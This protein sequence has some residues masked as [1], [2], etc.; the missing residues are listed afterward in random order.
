MSRVASLQCYSGVSGDMLLGALIDLGLE[1]EFL[2]KELKKLPL[3]TL[4]LEVGETERGG[5]RARKFTPLV[6]GRDDGFRT[7]GKVKAALRGSSLEKEVI[8]EAEKVFERLAEAEA[9][10]HGKTAGT[11]H[12]HELGS[13]DT[14]VDVVGAIVGWRRLGIEAGYATAVNIGGGEVKTGHGVFPVP[15]PATAHL[16]QG[17]SV[18]ADGEEGEKTTPTGAVLL[19]HLCRQERRL[20]LLRIEG[21]GYGAGRRDFPS[22]PNCLQILLGERAEE[23]EAEDAVV[24]ETNLDDLNPQVYGYLSAL[25]LKAGAM[26][27]Y[28]TPV[29]MKKGRPGHLLTII[30]SPEREKELGTIVF[31]ETGTLG[32]RFHRVERAKLRRETREVLTKY[33][34]VRVKTACLDGEEVHGAPE[35]E[36]CRRIAKLSGR[37]LKE[38]MDEVE[39]RRARPSV[40]F[41]DE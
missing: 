19:T 26:E 15:A 40:P 23:V 18:F 11:V 38:V 24:M 13:A 36:D 9:S 28:V 3:P 30:A 39:R 6:S 25:L 12:F 14:L 29:V 4:R 1:T 35:Y 2:E 5:I 16:L 31:R 10:V 22:R 20:P 8:R 41:D 32:Y 37:P 27:T 17:W 21:A 33:G 7:L 34:P